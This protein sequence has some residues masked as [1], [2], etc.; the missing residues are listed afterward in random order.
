MP[1][2]HRTAYHAGTDRSNQQN[3]E[4]SAADHKQKE[5]ESKRRLQA[6]DQDAPTCRIATPKRKAY[7]H[8]QVSTAEQVRDVIDKPPNKHIKNIC[9]YLWLLTVQLWKAERTLSW[10]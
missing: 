2:T 7:Q 3:N 1:V 10:V 9:K 5:L 6:F 4:R 8:S